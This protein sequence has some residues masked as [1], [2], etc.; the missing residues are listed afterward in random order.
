[1]D[2]TPRRGLSPAYRS[3]WP[4]LAD[5]V[6][7][8]ALGDGACALIG[9]G[10]SAGLASGIGSGAAGRRAAL[11]VGTSAA[12]RV[13][14]GGAERA[15]RP[16]GLF[17]YLLDPERVVLGAAR[18]N[19]G[20]LVDW[21]S[22][23]LRLDGDLVA[24]VAARPPGSHGLRAVSDLAGERSPDWPVTASGSVTGLHPDTTAPDI[25]QAFVEAAVVGL[26]SAVDSL[27]QAVAGL[28]LVG[29]GR[30]LASAAWR[31]LVADA[32]GRPLIPS[33]VEEASARG[34]AMVALEGLGWLDPRSADDLDGE[35]VLPDP[36]RAEAFSRLRSGTSR[37][38]Y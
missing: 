33:R 18:S 36:S 11:T 29:S 3:R 4:A 10:C 2:D 19:A 22:A 8:P 26:A 38:P 5:A 7:W 32:T 37:P 13:L 9:T 21:L 34:A 20:N 23:V 1:I 27:E 16:A 24:E 14:A 31:Q 15:A 6:W 12:V 28:T 35:V 30:A 17:A 25:A